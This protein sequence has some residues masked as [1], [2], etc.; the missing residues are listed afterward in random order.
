MSNEF[1]EQLKSRRSIRS[2]KKKP[3]KKEL[4]REIKQS[5]RYAPSATN[6]QPWRFIVI[7]QKNMIDNITD[8]IKNETDYGQQLSLASKYCPMDNS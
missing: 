8:V 2:Y 4:I 1:I 7:T 3:I 6:Q 5:G